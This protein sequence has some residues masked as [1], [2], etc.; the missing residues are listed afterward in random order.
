MRNVVSVL[1]ATPLIPAD[2]LALLTWSS[3]YYHYPIGEVMATALP[4]QLR[5]GAAAVLP[6][7]RRNP[8]VRIGIDG[9]TDDRGA[10]AYNQD[11]SDDRA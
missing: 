2:L 7:L 5:K 4:T 1:D 10:A 11:L 3:R 9:H 8:G 6:V